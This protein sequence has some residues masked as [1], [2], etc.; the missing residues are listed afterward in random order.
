MAYGPWNLAQ[1]REGIGVWLTEARIEQCRCAGA[2]A[3]MEGGGV[4]VG[5]RERA[6]QGSEQRAAAQGR[7]GRRG[8]AGT[9]LGRGSGVAE[10]HDRSGA[11]SCAAMASAV[12]MGFGAEAAV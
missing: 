7:P 12:A 1:K 10:R 4:R 3:L 9:L 5:A 6:L 8:G 2:A 11:E